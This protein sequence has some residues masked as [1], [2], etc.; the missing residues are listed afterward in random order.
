MM[1][2]EDEDGSNRG[3][4]MT[5]RGSA[6]GWIREGGVCV[7]GRGTNLSSLRRRIEDQKVSGTKCLVGSRN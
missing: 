1:K 4:S 6:M 5:D 2:M 7:C 3:R